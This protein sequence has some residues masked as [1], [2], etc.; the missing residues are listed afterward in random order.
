MPV[1]L[2][3]SCSSRAPSKT[4]GTSK[5]HRVARKGPT[6]PSQSPGPLYSAI[7]PAAPCRPSPHKPLGPPTPSTPSCYYS[8]LGLPAPMAPPSYSYSSSQQTAWPPT[9]IALTTSPMGPPAPLATTPTPIALTCKWLTISLAKLTNDCC[10]A[11]VGL[12]TSPYIEDI[13]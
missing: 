6:H 9:P 5:I 4:L 13:D 8:S 11:A 12:R 1:N 3:C 7:C 10:E 2:G